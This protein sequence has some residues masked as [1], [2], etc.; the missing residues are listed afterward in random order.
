[1]Q[2]LLFLLRKGKLFMLGLVGFIK[3]NLELSGK[4]PD[5][6][7]DGVSYYDISK[8]TLPMLNGE[9]QFPT[10]TFKADKGSD[11]VITE[12]DFVL[13][14]Q[15]PNN[16]ITEHLPLNDY[17][18][19]I[20]GTTGFADMINKN[21]ASSDATFT[22]TGS[23]YIE[24]DIKEDSPL[25]EEGDLKYIIF[26]PKLNGC[27]S[28]AGNI[29][30]TITYID[31]TTEELKATMDYYIS[32]NGNLFP[33]GMQISTVSDKGIKHIKLEITNIKQ[34][35]KIEYGSWVRAYAKTYTAPLYLTSQTFDF[36]DE[37]STQIQITADL[38]EDENIPYNGVVNL[39]SGVWASEIRV[40]EYNHKKD[41]Q[42]NLTE[43][44]SNK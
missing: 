32:S 40:N 30:C 14:A 3:K 22:A 11:I 27:G 31:E 29:I 18:E 26:G 38:Y 2:L 1:M 8:L 5:K 25:R 16:V 35:G 36:G 41:V 24:F 4:L 33:D 10:G 13:P 34:A 23:V 42:V 44:N 7:K 9:E 19:S 12:N 15:Q 39:G 43:F 37:V 21:S 6:W 20:Q 17:A 28:S